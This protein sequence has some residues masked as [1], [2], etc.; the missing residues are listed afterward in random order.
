MTAARRAGGPILVGLPAWVYLPA[1]LGGLFVITP[2]LA[3]LLRIDWANFVPLITSES[4]R[5]ALIL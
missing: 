3:I 4:S 1:A 2:L 5:A